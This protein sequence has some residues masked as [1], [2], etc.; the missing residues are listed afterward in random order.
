MSQDILISDIIHKTTS[1]W[2]NT[3]DNQGNI[4]IWNRAAEQISGYLY[5]EVVGHSDIWQKLY[6][7][8]SYREL[9]FN[10]AQDIINSNRSLADFESA[11]I[12]KSG[13]QVILS[14]NS[15]NLINDRGEVVGSIAIAR[16]ITKR[17]NERLRLQNAL[18]ETQENLSQTEQICEVLRY[19]NTESLA[20]LHHAIEQLAQSQ[21]DS[22][23]RA[24]VAQA[25]V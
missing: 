9:I 2:M 25:T 6:P 15:H 4:V 5:E 23:Q 14:W 22:H 20:T 1:I 18:R 7:D 11:I 3:L 16:D 8:P 17:R 12:T 24:L 19:G 10:K 13:K 21:L